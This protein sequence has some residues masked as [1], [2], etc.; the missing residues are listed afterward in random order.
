MAELSNENSPSTVPPTSTK[1]TVEESI[2]SR[3]DDSRED[4][5]REDGKCKPNIGNLPDDCKRI[6]AYNM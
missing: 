1:P 6:K 5:S 2:P 3:E 4:D